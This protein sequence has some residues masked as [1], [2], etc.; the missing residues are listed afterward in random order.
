MCLLI[1][2]GNAHGTDARWDDEAD[3]LEHSHTVRF[4][5]DL[6][7]DRG[8]PPEPRGRG[9]GEHGAPVVPGVDAEVPHA[10]RRRAQD[11]QHRGDHEPF[12]L[13][14]VLQRTQP[15]LVDVVEHHLEREE[16]RQQGPRHESM[17]PNATVATTVLLS[18]GTVTLSQ[19]LMASAM[20]VSVSMLLNVLNSGTPARTLVMSMVPVAAPKPVPRLGGAGRM[21]S[22]DSLLGLGAMQ[23]GMQMQAQWRFRVGK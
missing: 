2:G 3:Q 8:V 6:L 20:L 1:D 22:S 17:L 13:A 16:V 23:P 18:A 4:C 11:L 9:G 14:V 5:G 7:L 15:G 10:M 19:L 12:A 21:T